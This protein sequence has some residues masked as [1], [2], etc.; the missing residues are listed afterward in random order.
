M[1]QPKYDPQTYDPEKSYSARQLSR[2]DIEVAGL[3]V[4][5]VALT[6]LF[7]VAL[8]LMLFGSG[9]VTQAHAQAANAELHCGGAPARTEQQRELAEM[10]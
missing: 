2:Y 8:V 3:V 4:Y 9:S 10:T 5:V 6:L 7:V 1:P